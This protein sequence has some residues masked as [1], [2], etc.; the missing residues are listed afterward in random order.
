MLQLTVGRSKHVAIPKTKNARF[1]FITRSQL[2]ETYA[3]CPNLSCLFKAINAYHHRLS[4]PLHPTSIVLSPLLMRRYDT[5]RPLGQ[6]CSITTA[7]TLYK[8]AAT[9]IA[10]W[11]PKP[12]QL[13]QSGSHLQSRRPNV[14]AIGGPGSGSV[15]CSPLDLL[16]QWLPCFGITTI[17]LNPLGNNLTSP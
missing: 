13:P 15:S 8:L 7:R 14:E 11:S 1:N 2:K 3:A 10:L 17:S 16:V 9:K 5:S 4:T 12:R 6:S